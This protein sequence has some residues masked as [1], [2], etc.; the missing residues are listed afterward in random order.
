MSSDNI[1]PMK[2][3]KAQI[4]KEEI[5]HLADLSQLD[6]SDDEIEKFAK[7]LSDILQY[8]DKVKSVTLQ[9]E[10]KRNFKNMNRFREDDEM[11]ESGE[12]KDAILDAMSELEKGMLKVKKILSN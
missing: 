5:K 3:D 1:N 8:L 6:L 7:Q 11:F 12:H 9:G 4:T 2:N 10:V